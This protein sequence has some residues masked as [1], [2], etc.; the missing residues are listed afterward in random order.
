MAPIPPEQQEPAVRADTLAARYRHRFGGLPE[1]VVRAPGRIT[2]L[3]AHIDYSEGWV[4]PVA[5][6]RAVYVACARRPDR[7]V[8]LAADDVDDTARID[9][10]RLPPPVPRR[11]SSESGWAD[12]PAGV[13]WALAEA[14]HR[15]VGMNAVIAGDLPIAAGLSSSAALEA[16]LLLAWEELS[17][18]HAEPLDRARVGH[19]TEAEYLGLQSGIMDQFVILHARPGSA[20]FLDCRSLEH[21]LIS[22]PPR[23]RLLVADTG[24]RRQ[25]VGSKLNARREECRRATELLR[26]A[27]PAIATLRD[28]TPEELEAH[29]GLLPAPLDRRARHVVG[30]CERTRRAAEALRR[31]DL[32]EVG[33]LMRSSHESSRDHYEV[34]VPE[35]DTLAAEAWSTEGCFGARFPGAGFGG[36]VVALVD[37][38]AEEAVGA[39]MADAFEERFGRRPPIFAT[40]AAGAAEAVGRFGA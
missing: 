2:L 7:L 15:L 1:V 22:L 9:L 13:A 30:E 14:G 6:E 5:I 20:V 33:R 4:L 3:G 39:A 11:S 36:C 31:G 21:E 37:E 25:L 24:V 34:S 40:G 10:D 26:R 19:R 18:F 38:T 28:V 32:S 16:A 29:A 35:L 17:G 27:L 8:D 12:Y 23:A